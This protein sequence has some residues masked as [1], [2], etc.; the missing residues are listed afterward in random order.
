M[1]QIIQNNKKKI[2]TNIIRIT[3]FG[4]DHGQFSKFGNPFVDRKDAMY[5]YDG[6]KFEYNSNSSTV[7][8]AT[9]PIKHLQHDLQVK[10]SVLEF[11]KKKTVKL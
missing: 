4:N 2:E 10:V 11:S 8:M 1:I 7:K 5:F 3:V 6:I 9:L